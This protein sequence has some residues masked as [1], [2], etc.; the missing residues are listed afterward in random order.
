MSQHMDMGNGEKTK[1]EYLS[2]YCLVA[3]L[4]TS[5]SLTMVIRSDAVTVITLT[6][7]VFMMFAATVV[8]LEYIKHAVNKIWDNHSE[9]N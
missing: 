2:V 3:V 6:V 1:A 5:V 9:W 4:C 8:T 7:V